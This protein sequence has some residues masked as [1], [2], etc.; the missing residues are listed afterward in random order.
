MKLYIKQKVF[1]L[2]AKFRIFDEY[3]NTKY[4]VEGEVFT[5]VTK[6]HLYALGGNELAF[7]HQNVMSL[8]PIYFISCN[9]VDI[10]R[11]IKKFT[12]F[13][14]EYIVE[15]LGWTVE[16][17]FCAHEYQIYSDRGVVAIISRHWF[18]WG[19]TYEIDISDG[20]DEVVVLSVVLIIDAAIATSN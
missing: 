19:D 14:E 13:R 6:L 18:A 8:L 11:V 4:L 15:G 17:D 12:F 5:L 1:S 7:I 20:F 10:A 16:G 3:E 2:G 9:G